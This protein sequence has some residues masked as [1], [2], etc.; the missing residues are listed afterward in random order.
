MA[1]IA[2]IKKRFN[3]KSKVIIQQANDLIAEYQAQGF[4]LTLR[5]LY[6]QFVSR[7]LLENTLKSYKNLGNT[8]SEA[9]LAGLV[10]WSS[11]ED[12]TRNLSAFA[13]W[14]DAAHRIRSS[15]ATFKLDVWEDQDVYMEC[16]I[17][18]DALTGVIAGI[19]D[20]W[21]VPYFACKGYNSSSEQHA[22]A[23]RHISYMEAGKTVHILH[24][25]DH[26]PSGIQMTEDNRTRL[27]MFTNYNPYGEHR[28]GLI[29]HRL[30]LNMDQVN[31]YKP[32]PNPAKEKDSRFKAY[33]KKY[34]R[35][36]W[37]LD[38][39]EPQVISKLV[40]REIKRLIDADA[41]E[42]TLAK[43]EKQR[44]KIIRISK[45]A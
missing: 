3:R 19:C 12:R 30:A 17:E 9:R 38:A 29:I 16:W 14:N 44:Q 25:G 36:S 23:Q 35:K 37:E 13:T 7:D 18:K 5:Q 10:D 45:K 8:I 43:E 33:K 15:A 27:G 28:E 21:R 24:L 11:M 40:E 1:K 2:Y 42:A 22:A 31:K 4:T 32:K 34:G 39:L 41:F 6:Y 26:D 20:E